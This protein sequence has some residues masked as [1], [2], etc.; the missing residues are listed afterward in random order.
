VD[1]RGLSIDSLSTAQLLPG[2]TRPS[3]VP[4]VAAWHGA[5]SSRA[6][7]HMS[8]GKKANSPVRLGATQAG[9][10]W[11]RARC[12]PS[13]RRPWPCL[14]GCPWQP[15]AAPCLASV[16]ACHNPASAPQAQPCV[17][18][19][20]HQCRCG[21]PAQA[22]WVPDG[23]ALIP[24]SAGDMHTG[25]KAYVQ[26]LIGDQQCSVRPGIA[27]TLNGLGAHGQAL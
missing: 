21:F 25:A 2:C 20:K 6:P 1:T 27:Q 11:S 9:P 14:P 24:M 5:H 12:G 4:K 19:S 13:V 26:H 3:A 23:H 7:H 8:S 16:G 10:C 15:G 17:R 22:S 18:A